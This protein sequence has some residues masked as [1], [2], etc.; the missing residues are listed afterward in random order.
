MSNALNS[1]YHER[2]HSRS[3]SSI[4]RNQNS[5]QVNNKKANSKNNEFP[6]GDFIF[7]QKEEIVEL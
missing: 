3:N 4:K 1:L 5:N 2:S 6:Y 7:I